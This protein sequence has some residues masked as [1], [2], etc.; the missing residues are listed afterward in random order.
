[1]ASASAAA[2]LLLLKPDAPKCSPGKKLQAL[3]ALQSA[4]T[5]LSKPERVSLRD[6]IESCLISIAGD[7]ALTPSLRSAYL[8]C[9]AACASSDDRIVFRV[10]DGLLQLLQPSPAP[11]APIAAFSQ[12][13]S[14]V[15][16]SLTG[17]CTDVLAAMLRI[18]KDAAASPR[19]RV[20]ASACARV[21]ILRFAPALSKTIPDIIKVIH[22][23]HSH[24]RALPPSTH[25]PFRPRLKLSGTSAPAST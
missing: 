22:T 9:L 11:L 12:L 20:A 16:H 5:Q 15:S 4:V 18:L 1:M 23:S 2:A 7:P 10:A 6:G 3:L 17:E 21:L 24:A 13:M 8:G 25:V 14:C 19:C